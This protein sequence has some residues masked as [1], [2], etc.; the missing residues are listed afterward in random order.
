LQLNHWRLTEKGI[1][2]FK[3]A[4][5]K[6][7]VISACFDFDVP[8]RFDCDYLPQRLDNFEVASITDIPL[9]EVLL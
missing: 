3:E 2:T 9:V 7:V 6:G 4:P 5:L 8:V 1:I